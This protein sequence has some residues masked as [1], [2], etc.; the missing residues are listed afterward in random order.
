MSKFD[1]LKIQMLPKHFSV[2]DR[3]DW[4]KYLTV[5]NWMEKD[6]SDIIHTMKDVNFAKFIDHEVNAYLGG[7][8][9]PAAIATAVMNIGDDHLAGREVVVRAGDYIALQSFYAARESGKAPKV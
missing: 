6:L 9:P 8:T 2:I 7:G 1:V 4:I 5:K 3:S